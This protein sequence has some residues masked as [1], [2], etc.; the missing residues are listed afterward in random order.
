MEPMLEDRNDPLPSFSCSTYNRRKRPLSTDEESLLFLPS[1]KRTVNVN[2][3]LKT[4]QIQGPLISGP[5]PFNVKSSILAHKPFYSKL[6]LESA[7]SGHRGC[8][9][10]IQWN[11]TGSLIITGS[12]DCRVNIWSGV[13]L[14]CKYPLLSSHYTGHT[15][16]IFCSQF[17]PFSS[18]TQ[19]LSAGMDGEIRLTNVTTSNV[20][21]LDPSTIRSTMADNNANNLIFSSENMI[22]KF[23]FMPDSSSVF[24]STHHDGTV[25]LFDLRAPPTSNETVL[26]TLKNTSNEKVSINSICFDTWKTLSPGTS[27]VLGACDPFVRLCDL[28][29]ITKNGAKTIARYC[30]KASLERYSK[31]EN[32]YT[33]S[34]SV[35]G[36]DLNSI[37]EC[38]ATYSHGNAYLFNMNPYTHHEPDSTATDT[39]TKFAD[40]ETRTVMEYKGHRNVRTFLKEITFLGN[41]QYVATGSDCGHLFIWDKNTGKIVNWLK[42]DSNVV[43]GVAPHPSGEP[44][45]GTCG[46]DSEG[47]IWG[48]GDVVTFDKE[49]LKKSK[50]RRNQSDIDPDYFDGDEISILNLWNFLSMMRRRNMA[51]MEEDNE[52]EDEDEEDEPE[53]DV[54]EEEEVEPSVDRAVQM[55]QRGNDFW[56]VKDWTNALAWYTKSENELAKITESSPEKTEAEILC[57]LN[58]LSCYL[59]LSQF[60]TVLTESASLVE[61]VDTLNPGMQMKLYFRRGK[62]FMELSRWDEALEE[63]NKC[64]VLSSQTTVISLEDIQK[65]VLE[66]QQNKTT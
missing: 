42:A 60:E 47:K 5:E 52:D 64:V 36:V 61:N 1:N 4:R 44:R 40:V 38:A 43:N 18:D 11:S 45:F 15:R 33:G 30:P 6:R 56:K 49:K 31:S 16:N 62:A 59:K 28:R 22:L 26:L 55:R 58:K 65:C 21:G 10:S 27:F 54:E 20:L 46:I 8:V 35:T 3:L 53:E 32:S 14:D 24:V 34:W 41:N 23:A 50:E 29:S 12:D 19:F 57:S 39:S 7:L 25:R 13:G 37:G 63:M 48:P 9:N 2:H 66:I 17:V 51:E